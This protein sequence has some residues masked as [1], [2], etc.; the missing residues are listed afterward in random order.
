VV[1][2]GYLDEEIKK[3]SDPALIQKLF[4]EKRNINNLCKSF[5][6]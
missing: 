5:L 2:E 1:K 4:T 3:C 6:K